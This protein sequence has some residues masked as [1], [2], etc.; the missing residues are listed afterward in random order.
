MGQIHHEGRSRQDIV[1]RE[2][3]AMTC[4]FLHAQTEPAR[5]P[6]SVGAALAGAGAAFTQVSRPKASEPSMAMLVTIVEAA[7]G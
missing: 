1:G 2:G 6:A 7:C 5:R 4:F 3:D